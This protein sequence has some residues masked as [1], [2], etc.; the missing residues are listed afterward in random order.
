PIVYAMIFSLFLGNVL[1]IVYG[2]SGSRYFGKVAY[3]PIRFIIPVVT[4]LAVVGAFAV[5]N[6][7][8]DLFVI[9]AVG[10][11]GLVFVKYDYPLVSPVLGV[12]V[13]DIAETGFARGWLLNTESWSTFLT[14]SGVS[15]G[16]TVLIT[17]SL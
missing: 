7:Q 14:N 10:V 5:R 3:I 17:L 15:I 8:F 2:L 11:L 9:L 6:A 4:V 12:I 1:I 13:G 16:L